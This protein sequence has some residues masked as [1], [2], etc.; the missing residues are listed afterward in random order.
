VASGVKTGRERRRRA[1][2]PRERACH[3]RWRRPAK[4]HRFD[5][6][7]FA[8]TIFWN[9]TGVYCLLSIGRGLVVLTDR[10]D[11]VDRQ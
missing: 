7:K 4:S 5:G 9:E 1:K 6:F 10:D 2:N 8:M 11:G 3:Y